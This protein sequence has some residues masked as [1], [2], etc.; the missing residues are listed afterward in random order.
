MNEALYYY[1]EPKK[2]KKADT[3]R[4]HS[5]LLLGLKSVEYGFVN[6]HIR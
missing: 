3:L 2:S 5:G 1:A 4:R 6:G